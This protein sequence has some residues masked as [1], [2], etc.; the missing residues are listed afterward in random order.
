[1]AAAGFDEDVS[2]AASDFGVAA[3]SVVF[4]ASLVPMESGFSHV[5]SSVTSL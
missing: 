5:V 4:A 1:M 3:A 2:A